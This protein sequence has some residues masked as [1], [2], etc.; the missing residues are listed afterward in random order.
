MTTSETT[1]WWERESI[2][3]VTLYPWATMD[4][5]T[6]LSNLAKRNVNTAM[7]ICKESDGRVF[8]DS[9]T[10]PNQ[11]PSR[12]ILGE[13]TAAASDYGIRVVPTFFTL[14]D[15]YLLERDPELVQIARDGTEI[16]Y[17]NVSFEWMY[18]V[19]PSRTEVRDHLQRLTQEVSEYDVDGIR[20]SHLEFQPVYN[21]GTDH[22]SCFCDRCVERAEQVGDSDA[23]GHASWLAARTEAST[24]LFAAL[25]DPFDDDQMVNLQ[26]EVFTDAELTLRDS[27]ETL[28]LNIEALADHVDVLT[29]R[30]A[31]V[32]M[33]LHPLWIRDVTRSLHEAVDPPILPSIRTAGSG[34]DGE[35]LPPDELHTAIQMALHGGSDGVSLFSA[36]ANIGRITDEQWE[37]VE[38]S[39]AGIAD[40]ADDTEW[41][42]PR[43]DDD[44]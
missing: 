11:V 7:V 22:L 42:S 43:T 19:C 15:K 9:D 41:T 16:R 28:G 13:L 23:D 20:F 18:W 10:V 30:T 8:Y 33:D 31:H 34:S 3:A 1:S 27:H 26:V 32:D 12:D 37:V 36:G 38:E 24:E 39:F 5:D 44:R 40:L 6:V 21:D 2:R 14:C 17:P 4:V 29:P 35:R 25:A